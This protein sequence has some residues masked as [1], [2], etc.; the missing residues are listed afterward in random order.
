MLPS[1]VTALTSVGLEHTEWL[2]E[3]EEEIAAE[4]LAVLR[5]HSTLV[6][7]RVGDG[8]RELAERTAAERERPPDRAPATP[9]RGFRLAR[10]GR[11]PAAK[12]RGRHWRPPR[13]SSGGSTPTGS[14]GRGRGAR[15]AGPARAADGRPA[16]DPRRRP[17]PGRRP[18]AR[19]GAARGRRRARRS[20]PAW[21][22]WPTRTPR[23]SSRP[24]RPGSSSPSAPSSRPSVWHE[25][26]VPAPA[27]WRQRDWPSSPR[28]PGSTAEVVR[29]P[30]AALRR[31]VEAAS[32]RGGVALVSGSHYLLGYARA[33]G[34]DSSDRT[35]KLRTSAR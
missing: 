28:R 15:A 34:S 10:P 1:R 32:E 7:G 2:G 4:K 16:A 24:W 6:L 12:L 30:E 11:L 23:G 21:R 19:R 26:V 14:R 35:L 3:T 31:A 29:R 33:P 5:D 13:L 8:V 27:R 17:Q 18:R 20:S 25:R 22:C 9:A